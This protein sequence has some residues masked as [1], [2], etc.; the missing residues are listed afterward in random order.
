MIF[1]QVQIY[2]KGKG[3]RRRRKSLAPMYWFCWIHFQW[4]TIGPFILF[5]ELAYR[6]ICQRMELYGLYASTI[7]S[8]LTCF[9]QFQEWSNKLKL[10]F[11]SKYQLVWVYMSDCTHISLVGTFHNMHFYM[12]LSPRFTLPYPNICNE[13][14]SLSSLFR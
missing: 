12:F 14:I 5:Y 13:Y 1:V 7:N 11:R 10:I 4:T 9:C 6:I 2:Q 8:I 3:G